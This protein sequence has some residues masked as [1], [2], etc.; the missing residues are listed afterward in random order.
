[1]EGVFEAGAVTLKIRPYLKI[2][3]AEIEFLT[4]KKIGLVA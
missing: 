2:I 1:M 3:Y 4:N